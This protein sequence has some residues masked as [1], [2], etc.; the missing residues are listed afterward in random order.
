M[1]DSI[2]PTS[3]HAASSLASAPSMLWKTGWSLWTQ[4]STMYQAPVELI[5]SLVAGR[6]PLDAQD[7]RRGLILCHGNAATVLQRTA[8]LPYLSRAYP[9]CEWHLTTC[10][11]TDEIVSSNPCLT[12]T[13]PVMNP[14]SGTVP[15]TAEARL[16]AMKFDVVLCPDALEHP[17]DYLLAMKLRVPTR[18]GFAQ[19]THHQL[20]TMEV[21]VN[22]AQPEAALFRDMVGDVTSLTP[23]WDLRPQIF[24][25][26][27][28][29]MAARQLHDGLGS[30]RPLR[31]AVFP[32]VTT[33]GGV[34][35]PQFWLRLLDLMGADGRIQPVLCG[36]EYERR[37]LHEI[38]DRATFNIPVVAAN[39]NYRVLA[40]FLRGCSA[41]I[42][43]DSPS[44]HIAT[45]MSVPTLYFRN[46]SVSWAES[47]VYCGGEQSL[48]PDDEERLTPMEQI[49]VLE[50]VKP[51]AVFAE[52][53]QVLPE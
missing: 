22:Y 10:D 6:P 12:R 4:R 31:I 53:L 24:P 39:L 11:D 43:P 27:E 42:G 9:D 47:A 51:E 1:P 52:I 19:R 45:A 49:R 36:T 23:R 37:R 8:S 25:R 40:A 35:F 2:P 15:P 16:R 38:A 44:R 48:I 17:D 26:P 7:W 3:D 34:W 18:I 29:E 41:R 14:V 50:R 5:S 32:F 46:M 33:S 20:V 30:S 28:D 13:W 21:P